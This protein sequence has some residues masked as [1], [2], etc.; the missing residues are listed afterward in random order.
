MMASSEIR[1]YTLD[2]RGVQSVADIH[3]A[4]RAAFDFP[5][6]YG[7]NWDAMWDCLTDLFR[8]DDEGEIIIIGL[9]SMPKD[10]QKYAQKMCKVFEYLHEEYPKITCRYE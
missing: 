10:L 6:Y 2:L 4:A 9:S 3:A 1:R 8:E 7:C 5:D